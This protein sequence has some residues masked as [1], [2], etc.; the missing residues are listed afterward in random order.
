MNLLLAEITFDGWAIAATR[1]PMHQSDV[2]AKRWFRVG[3]VR[4]RHATNFCVSTCG[5]GSNLK[6][7]TTKRGVTNGSF[8]IPAPAFT[9]CKSICIG[10][11]T[12]HTAPSDDSVR[13]RVAPGWNTRLRLKWR[14]QSECREI[15][16]A[17]VPS[18][19]Y[20]LFGA[21]YKRRYDSPLF[22]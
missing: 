11:K 21:C 19:G 7:S 9:R 4:F 2:V 1:L 20:A 16:D 15:V 18:V 17:L 8:A 13:D 22:S 12:N 5:F 14:Q 6:R 3:P 10:V